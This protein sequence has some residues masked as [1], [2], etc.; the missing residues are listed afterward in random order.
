MSDQHPSPG[1][2]ALAGVPA[3]DELV[4]RAAHVRETLRAD[5]PEAGRERR[6]TESCVAAISDAGLTRLT[7]ARRFGGFETDARTVLDVVTELGRGCG[8]PAWATAAYN[9]AR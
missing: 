3:H 4:S 9:S 5:A 2:N 8:S 6:L 7:T 1:V